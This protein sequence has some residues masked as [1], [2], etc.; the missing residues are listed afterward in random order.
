MQITLKP[1]PTSKFSSRP[2]ESF[3]EYYKVVR[4]SLCSLLEE[5]MTREKMFKN[6]VNP[7]TI[8]L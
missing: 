8:G 1:P 7:I 5:N 6:T 4:G 2:G 3:H